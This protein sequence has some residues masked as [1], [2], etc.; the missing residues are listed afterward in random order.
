MWKRASRASKANDASEIGTDRK[1]VIT[2]PEIKK[3]QE[4]EP[5]KAQQKREEQKAEKQS[6]CGCG[7]TPPFPIKK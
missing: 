7:C 5:E 6:N 1:E 3:E 4:R 2:M